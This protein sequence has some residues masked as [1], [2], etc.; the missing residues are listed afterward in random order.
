MLA[1]IAIIFDRFSPSRSILRLLGVIASMHW[2]PYGGD[3]K[4]DVGQFIAFAKK[5]SNC[6]LT[7]ND[8]IQHPFL[9]TYPKVIPYLLRNQL[10]VKE[11]RESVRCAWTAT[12]SLMPSKDHLF[13][14][15][16][17]WLR[18]HVQPHLRQEYLAW[19]DGFKD[20]WISNISYLE[21][22]I[23]RT[24]NEVDR[25]ADGDLDCARREQSY[26]KCKL[27]HY[28]LNGYMEA[29]QGLEGMEVG[30]R[31]LLNNSSD[32]NVTSNSE[33]SDCSSSEH[34]LSLDTS[35]DEVETDDQF[36]GYIYARHNGSIQTNLRI[37][38]FLESFL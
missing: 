20:Q 30:M 9:F 29:L 13:A 11:I 1:E 18:E 2:I 8:A 10:E 21:K 26:L 22:D 25:D 27:I 19:L 37:F 35:I 31:N 12:K 32:L 24:M 34:E 14:Y 6:E 15:N 5:A 33:S 16:E 3:D 28:L 7:A 36:L 4:S 17:R 23:K 38:N